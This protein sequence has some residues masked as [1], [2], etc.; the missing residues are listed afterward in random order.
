M[1]FVKDVGMMERIENWVIWSHRFL[2]AQIT[3][4]AWSLNPLPLRINAENLAIA[5]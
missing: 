4:G 2:T 5:P 3:V 1:D